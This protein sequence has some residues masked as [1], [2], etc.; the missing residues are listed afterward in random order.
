MASKI[1]PGE[2]KEKGLRRMTPQRQIHK[3]NR[4][5]A[6]KY[7]RK[8]TS[9]LVLSYTYCLKMIAIYSLVDISALKLAFYC[10]Y[11]FILSIFFNTN[12]T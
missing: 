2:R 11:K 8:P 9:K 4:K 5:P 10:I 12:N 7:H 6:H 1:K 3:Y